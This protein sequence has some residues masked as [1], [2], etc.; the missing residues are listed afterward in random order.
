MVNYLLRE[1]VQ[2]GRSHNNYSLVAPYFGNDD[3]FFPG[4]GVGRNTSYPLYLMGQHRFILEHWGL[5]AE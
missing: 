5:A 3:Y 1:E 4:F 2:G